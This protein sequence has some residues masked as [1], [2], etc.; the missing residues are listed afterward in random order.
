MTEAQRHPDIE[1]YIKDRSLEQITDWLATHCQPL[2][3]DFEQGQVHH[4][5]G[6]INDQ[7]VPVMVHEKVS[8]KAWTSVWFNS[9]QTPWFKDLDC[10]EQASKELDT[11]IR[12]IASGWNTG[13]DPD[14]WWKVEQ[15]NSEKIQWRT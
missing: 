10:A 1:I 11:Q 3:R 5:V 15:G 6:L 8:G 2:K 7:E 4:F 9:D 14:E 12:C 13:D